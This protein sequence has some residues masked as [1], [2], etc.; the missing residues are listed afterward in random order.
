MNAALAQLRHQAQHSAVAASVFVATEG[1]FFLSDPEY[2]SLRPEIV[3]DLFRR[4]RVS[5]ARDWEFVQQGYF[6]M[7]EVL[8]VPLARHL[9]QVPRWLRDLPELSRRKKERRYSDFPQ[10]LD[11]DRYPKYYTRNFH[12]QTDGWLSSRSAAIWDLQSD[13]FFLG[14][15]PIMQRAIIVE[16]LN[17]LRGVKNPSILDL[18]CGTGSLLTRI[19]QALPD[20]ELFALDLSPFYLM[21]ARRRLAHVPRASFLLENAEQIRVS[22]QRFDVVVSIGLFHELP[23]LVRRAVLSE[24]RRVL[25]P[26]GLFVLSDALQ[27][28]DHS[29]SEYFLARLYN[30]FHEPFLKDFMEQDLQGDL[31]RCGFQINKVDSNFLLNNIVMT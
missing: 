5:L 8:E 13:L 10:G 2:P 11:L 19:H 17:A 27:V 30:L 18:G 22:P 4:F 23:R 12:C 25:K 15:I 26:G 28:E 14:T 21:E 7:D 3:R 1:S 9:P 16:L 29:L 20:A 31:N 6:S 24:V